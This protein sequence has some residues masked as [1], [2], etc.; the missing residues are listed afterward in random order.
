MKKSILKKLLLTTCFP[1]IL[2][3]NCN[4]DELYEASN[5]SS[6]K[7]TSRYITFN[8]L[9][10]NQK[11]FREFQE[12]EHKIT[13]AKSSSQGGLSS[14]L[15][16]ISQY[17]FSI[18]TDKI[19]LIEQGDYKSYTLP[20]YRNEETEKTENL[21]I[22]QKNDQVNAYLSKYTLT[23]LEKQK[24]RNFEYV[25]MYNKTEIS[26]LQNQTQSEPCY[27]II[28]TPTAWNSQGQVIASLVTAV[29]VDCPDGGGSSGNGGGGGSSSGDGSSSGGN[30]SGA[31]WSGGGT[32]GGGWAGGGSGSAGGSVSAGGGSYGGGGAPADSNHVTIPQDYETPEILTTPI[33]NTENSADV[34]NVN[35]FYQ[36][37]TLQQQQWV[38][39]DFNNLIIYNQLIQYQRDNAWIDDS[40]Q[41]AN[42]IL[43]ASILLEINALAV[44][45]DYDN[46]VNQMSVSEK[47][48]FNNLLPNRKLWYM[49]SASKAFDKANELYPTST[50][51]GRGDAF[52][53]AFW[54]GLCALTLAGNLGE[55]LTTAH[56]N[57]PSRYPFNYKETE[58]DLY[59]NERGRQI[60]IMSNFT[61]ILDNII[62]DLNSGYLRYL[63]N[64]N[65][66]DDNKATF[67]SVLIPTD[68]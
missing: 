33:L 3:T 45:G 40:K 57:K 66:N 13:I 62:N 20:T 19:L 37:L 64:L 27:E 26:K 4:K 22:T 58:M 15:V 41:F 32:W 7:V 23:E 68:Q 65:S 8:E 47:A 59:N 10:K 18:D 54:N 12:V 29:E 56:E 49:V 48:I 17:D 2:F 16:Y 5:P 43:N 24:I 39:A 36:S 1:A 67:N 42:E 50:H 52:R 51:N 34:R 35:R 63:N 60:A 55:Q 25:D 31:G 44:W 6:S 9:E 53:H 38:R 21:V 61:N 28:S 30:W 11:A 46:F 14:R